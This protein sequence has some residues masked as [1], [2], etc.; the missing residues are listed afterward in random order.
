MACIHGIE[1]ILIGLLFRYQ[2]IFEAYF[3]IGLVPLQ[4][5]FSHCFAIFLW[6][7]LVE[8]IGDW[9]YGFRKR[10]RR[11]LFLE[12]P[13]IHIMYFVFRRQIFAVVRSRRHKMTQTIIG[14][15]SCHFC[16]GQLRKTIIKAHE[17]TSWIRRRAWWGRHWHRARRQ[18][19]RG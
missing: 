3:F 17:Q 10:G 15:S 5:P 9:L 4:Y 11:V 14:N 1:I 2:R 13:T 7:V 19:W 8:P 16:F 12:A 6:N 18:G